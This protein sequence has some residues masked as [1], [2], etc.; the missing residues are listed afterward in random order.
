MCVFQLFMTLLQQLCAH[1]LRVCQGSGRARLPAGVVVVRRA[2]GVDRSG[3]HEPVR[4]LEERAGRKGAV[5]AAVGHGYH[6][7]RSD[8]RQHH[9]AGSLL[10]NSY[11]SLILYEL[12]CI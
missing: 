3:R 12:S 10:G 1:D 6:S 11:P 7:A 5:D 9:G 8:P 2:G 4:V